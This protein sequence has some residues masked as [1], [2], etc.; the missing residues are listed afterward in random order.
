M[1]LEICPTCEEELIPIWE[2]KEI[3]CKKC[4]SK[5]KINDLAE[6][7]ED[8]LQKWDRSDLI[9]FVN[10]LLSRIQSISEEFREL[11]S[12]IETLGIIVEQNE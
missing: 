2:S 5:I 12:R 4:R 10:Y 11:E 8:K 3:K 9:G 6:I 1:S 7:E